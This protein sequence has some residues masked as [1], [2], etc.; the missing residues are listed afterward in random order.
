MPDGDGEAWIKEGEETSPCELV[1]AA[2]T[3]DTCT[4]L[5]LLLCA[6]ITQVSK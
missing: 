4:Q 1:Q 5:P 3:R 6:H 2:G